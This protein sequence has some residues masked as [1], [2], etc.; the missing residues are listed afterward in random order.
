MGPS[1]LQIKIKIL[2]S[3]TNMYPT[4]N[5][6]KGS[7]L[8]INEIPGQILVPASLPNTAA[9]RPSEN[10]I[11]SILNRALKERILIELDT[12]VIYANITIIP[13]KY[14]KTNTH[15]NHEFLSPTEN[16]KHPLRRNSDTM[17]VNG[18]PERKIKNMDVI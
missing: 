17:P 9:N 1:S 15:K 13:P 5:K 6:A 14:T 18:D 11:I 3:A 16:A 12:L 8:L 7:L 10:A 2:I 4:K